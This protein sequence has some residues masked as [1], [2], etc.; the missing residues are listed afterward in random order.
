MGCSS[1][2]EIAIERELGRHSL[3][4]RPNERFIILE[5]EEFKPQI[6]GT[7]PKAIVYLLDGKKRRMLLSEKE[8]KDGYIVFLGRVLDNEVP[9]EESAIMDEQV[10]SLESGEEIT[11]EGNT[12][13]TGGIR[14]RK[15]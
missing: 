10:I 1:P 8:S 9:G 5:V 7:P 3:P 13:D 15:L 12:I 14:L 2:P 4:F 11:I 6:F